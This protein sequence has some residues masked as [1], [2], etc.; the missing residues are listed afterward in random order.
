MRI[1]GFWDL[2]SCRLVKS[3][4]FRRSLLPLFSGTTEVVSSSYKLFTTVQTLAAIPLDRP[5]HFCMHFSPLP[6]VLH[7]PLISSPA[8]HSIILILSGEVCTSAASQYAVSSGILLYSYLL[9][10]RSVHSL[11]IELPRPL[12]SKH[13]NN[14]ADGRTPSAVATL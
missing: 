4:T 9:P 5:L 6:R 10:C 11:L 3:P 1:Q 12:L 13:S 14:D 8:P 7:A 2:M